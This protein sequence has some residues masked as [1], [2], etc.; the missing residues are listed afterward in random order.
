MTN[1][2]KDMLITLGVSDV[3]KSRDFYVGLGF[4]VD[5]DGYTADFKVDG[6]R[7]SLYQ[8]NKLAED[9]NVYNPLEIV[10]GFTGITLAYNLDS[11][12][13]VDEMYAKVQELGGS[14]EHAPEKAKDWNGYHFYFRDLDGHYWEI[15][16]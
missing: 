7:F 8:L 2:N 4:K 9:V 11:K 13:A 6:I 10:K 5:L 1:P 14:A 3:V 16:Y 12:E 15:A